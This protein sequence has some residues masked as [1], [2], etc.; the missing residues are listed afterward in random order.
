MNKIY[1]YALTILGPDRVG[2][3]KDVSS[4]L[5]AHKI[6]IDDSSM[7][8][9][10]NEFAMILIIASPRPLPL[11]FVKKI[12][13]SVLRHGGGQLEFYLKPILTKNEIAP[14]SVGKNGRRIFVIKV[15]GADRTGIVAKISSV[16]ASKKI[17][18]TDMKTRYT[19]DPGEIF[20]TPG[21]GRVSRR[22]SGTYILLIE[23]AP[24]DRVKLSSIKKSLLKAARSLKCN[25]RIDEYET[26]DI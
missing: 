14:I 6:N 19:G 4:F 12:K 25:L 20:R 5:A 10:R 21:V 26:S 1:C 11:D 24:P 16:L 22:K 15:Y 7:T 2:I 3:V 23:A 18:I 17:N 9:L 8:R 13:S